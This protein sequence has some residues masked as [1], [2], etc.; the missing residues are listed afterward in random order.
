MKASDDREEL[1]FRTIIPPTY[2]STIMTMVPRNS[3]MGEARN[4]LRYTLVRV[5]VNAWLISVNLPVIFLLPVKGLHDT[6]SGQGLFQ[7]GKQGS[8]LGLQSSWN[9]FLRFFPIR[10]M[11]IPLNGQQ[12]QGKQGQL[13]IDNEHGNQEY[14]DGDGVTEYHF[15][16]THDG[17]FYLIYIH[18]R[19]CDIISPFLDSEKYDMGRRSDLTV[20]LVPDILD[21][22]YPDRRDKI[23]CQEFK[24]G[25]Q[26]GHNHDQ[27][28]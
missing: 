20:D 27:Y 9:S 8:L 14:D 26:Q 7:D 17:K 21:D 22:T 3:L 10:P 23:I 5:S 28:D 24:S 12:Y 15:Q 16:G 1:W 19:P 4:R 2:I 18:A 6:H 25:F 13:V 11:N